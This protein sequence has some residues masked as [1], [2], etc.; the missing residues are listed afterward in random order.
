MEE[1]VSDGDNSKVDAKQV[2]KRDVILNGNVRHSRLFFLSA[3][4]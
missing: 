1:V 4:A 3:D 2:L